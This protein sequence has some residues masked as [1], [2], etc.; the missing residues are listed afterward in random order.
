MTYFTGLS[1]CPCVTN[2]IVPDNRGNA[3]VEDALTDVDIQSVL[4]LFLRRPGLRMHRPD[5]VHGVRADRP[6][7]EDLHMET[8]REI[9]IVGHCLVG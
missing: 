8:G 2:E 4:P 6:G 1:R 5:G 3:G 7:A 9:M